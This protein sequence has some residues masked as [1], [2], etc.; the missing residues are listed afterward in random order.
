MTVSKKV[1]R[2]QQRWIAT[3]E[4]AHND[5]IIWDT[6]V[7]GNII[8]ADR[9]EM[10]IGAVDSKGKMKELKVA[11]GAIESID[12]AD[13]VGVGDES[14]NQAEEKDSDDA[15]LDITASIKAGPSP[16]LPLFTSTPM[17]SY[18]KIDINHLPKIEID[19]LPEMDIDHLPP[20]LE[21]PRE[22][23][24]PISTWKSSLKPNNSASVFRSKSEIKFMQLD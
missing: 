24:I 10:R 5:H 18:P 7:V 12:E 19:H 11:V 3:S 14:D 8:V 20:A 2:G 9:D 17:T 16:P 1:I 13:D 21:E 15:T 4:R 6:P 22:D 23:V